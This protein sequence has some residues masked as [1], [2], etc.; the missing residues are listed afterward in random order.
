MIR[1][2]AWTPSKIGCY[3]NAEEYHIATRV[4]IE[5]GKQVLTYPKS[6]YVLTR[7]FEELGV[8]KSLKSAQLA[9]QKIEDKQRRL[10]EATSVP[11]R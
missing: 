7:Y 8:F 11:P 6:G 3:W 4:L 10:L 1:T 5:N 9:A 2:L